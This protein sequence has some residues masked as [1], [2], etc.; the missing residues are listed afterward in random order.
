M[1]NSVANEE[2]TLQVDSEGVRYPFS[3]AQE[4]Q[5]CANTVSNEMKMTL[6]KAGEISKIMAATKAGLHN[7]T[8]KTQADVVALV[9][10]A[11]ARRTGKS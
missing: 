8:R 1:A 5:K 11:M 2:S 4:S 10:K 3:Q 7:A 9:L 6:T